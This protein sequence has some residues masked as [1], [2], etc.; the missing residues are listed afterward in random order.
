MCFRTETVADRS[1]FQPPALPDHNAQTS[2]TGHSTTEPPTKRLSGVAAL[3]RTSVDSGASSRNRAQPST[4]RAGCGCSANGR[5]GIAGTTVRVM[6]FAL[7]LPF[8]LELLFRASAMMACQAIH[9]WLGRL[10][11]AEAGGRATRVGLRRGDACSSDRPSKGRQ[12]TPHELGSRAILCGISP[13]I[14]KR[15]HD[16]P[17]G[18]TWTSAS[19]LNGGGARCEGP[20]GPTVW[21]AVSCGATSVSGG[22]A[23]VRVDSCK[24]RRGC[25]LRSNL[26][27]HAARAR[28]IC[29]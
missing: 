22:G 16:Q 20:P 14:S 18:L 29:L 13:L 3:A 19:N 2:A 17:F 9:D 25:W 27:S 24:V 21:N 15:P 6:N 8:L 5:P 23:A 1:R 26:V 4:R 12:R 7:V 10:T 11:W 28:P